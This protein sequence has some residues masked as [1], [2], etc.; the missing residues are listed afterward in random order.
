MD[1]EFIQRLS[2]F[3]FCF[4]G[5]VGRRG[6]PL[7]SPDEKAANGKLQAVGEGSERGDSVTSSVAGSDFSFDSNWD[8]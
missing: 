1:T 8:A 4:Y 3:C 2:L 5:Q 6:G 7:F